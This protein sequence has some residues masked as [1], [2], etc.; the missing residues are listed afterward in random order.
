MTPYKVKCNEKDDLRKLKCLRNTFSV[1]R[2]K[3]DYF[4][5]SKIGFR[6]LKKKF[7]KWHHPSCR[8]LYCSW[9]PKRTCPK[10]KYSLW[11]VP[12]LLQV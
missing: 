5:F 4:Y 10:L 1:Y 11:G 2:H 6:Y 3:Y 9:R 12:S 8:I 7:G